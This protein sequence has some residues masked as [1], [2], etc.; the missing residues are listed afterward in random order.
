[1]LLIHLFKTQR[2]FTNNGVSLCTVTKNS[3]AIRERKI[4]HVARGSWQAHIQPMED[5][6]VLMRG[7]VRVK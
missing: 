1:M 3:D 4:D 6:S 7:K 2:I 5:F